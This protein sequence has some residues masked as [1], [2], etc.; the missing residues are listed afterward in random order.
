MSDDESTS[1]EDSTVSASGSEDSDE[2]PAC[3]TRSKK[4]AHFVES[5]DEGSGMNREQEE[6]P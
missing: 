5:E 2:G 6:K 4:Q 1:E 3:R